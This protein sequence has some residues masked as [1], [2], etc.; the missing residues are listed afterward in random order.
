M[1]IKDIRSNVLDK[2]AFPVQAIS[3]DT[4]TSGAIIDTADFDGGG[5]F[6]L[7]CSAYTD[8]TYTPLIQES[9]D[10]GMSGATAV[11]DANLIGTEAGAALSAVTASGANLNSIG[12]FGTKRYVRLQI[13]SAS[14]SSGAT[15]GAT[16]TGSPEIVPSASLSA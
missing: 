11:A 15:V 9:D 5:M 14:T 2:Y 4:T 16:F 12:F 7:L 3:S 6:T 8:G 10:S 1:P 13:V